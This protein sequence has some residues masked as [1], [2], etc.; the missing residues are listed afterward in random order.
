M[1]YI[2]IDGCKGGWFIFGLG[3][4]GAF[5]FNVVDA[6]SGIQP[7]LNDAKQ[8]LIDIPIGLRGEH[9]DERLCDKKARKIL[10]RKGSSVFPAP[11]RHSL[12]C[13]SFE[14]ANKCNRRYTGRGLSQQSW[15]IVPK[16]R[17]VDNFLRNE[18][19]GANIREMHPEICFST[20]N[21]SRVM[22]NNKKSEKGFE[23]RILI[24]SR[25]IPNAYELV[26]Q[27]M[28]MYQ[29][30]VV[31]RDDIVDAMVG[32][33]AASMKDR[34]KTIPRQPEVDE[35][36]LPMEIVYAV[37]NSEGDCPF[38]SLLKFDDNK[39]IKASN[40]MT[41]VIRDGYPISPGHTLIIPRRHAASF[42]E[43]STLE[44]DS[45]FELIDIAKSQLDREFQ[46]DSY[47]IG[48]NDGTDAGQTVPH[49]HIHL[50][51]RYKGDVEDPR[52]GVRWIIP[53]K[54]KYWED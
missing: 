28:D 53:E 29:R 42:F 20:L 49:L 17:E 23:E 43:L 6:I 36:G 51:P 22:L 27:A 12:S 2:G 9:T 30:K 3:A 7:F 50:I 4:D 21:G 1:K 24:L 52:G 26:L 16:I 48:I 13:N 35:C 11:S 31:A 25:Y 45:I 8:I 19:K 37:D 14:F 18:G 41:V 10:G 32:A 33:V 34:L 15:A 40:D 39:R 46:P 5:S 44:R 38:C 54:A 47:N